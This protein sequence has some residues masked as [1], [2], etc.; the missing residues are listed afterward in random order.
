M[1][2][3][4]PAVAPL[5]TKYIDN[6]YQ[7]RKAL[8]AQCALQSIDRIPNRPIE[9]LAARLDSAK[10]RIEAGSPDSVRDIFEFFQAM[11]RDH[12]DNELLKVM[13]G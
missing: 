11:L 1:A 13:V 3:K 6:V 4:V 2:W 8:D 5:D 7:V 9:E 10:A 12:C